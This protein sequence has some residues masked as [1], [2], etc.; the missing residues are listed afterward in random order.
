MQPRGTREEEGWWAREARRRCGWQAGERGRGEITTRARSC[1]HWGRCC[2]CWLSGH[3]AVAAGAVPSGQYKFYTALTS[4]VASHP[5]ASAHAPP[6]T[7]VLCSVRNEDSRSGGRWLCA[8][9]PGLPGRRE[10]AAQAT[11]LPSCAICHRAIEAW[12]TAPLD[13]SG[14]AVG[15]HTFG[16]ESNLGLRARVLEQEPPVLRPTAGRPGSPRAPPSQFGRA[17]DL[18]QDRL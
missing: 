9:S 17:A 11:T 7:S 15:T 6:E 16:S 1:W 14:E 18:A 12:T 10:R 3:C 13:C 5:R 2:C 8:P 4:A